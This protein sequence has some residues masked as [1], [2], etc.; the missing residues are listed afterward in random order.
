V[1]GFRFGVFE[2]DVQAG[3]LR[4]SGLKVRLQEQPF[5]VLSML[6]DRPGEVISRDEIR[7]RLWPRDT[8]VDF[9]HSLNAAI[10]RLRESLGD[11]AESPRYIATVPRRGYRFLAPVE[12]VGNGAEQT[13]D[14]QPAGRGPKTRFATPSRLAVA[15]AIAAAA[16][17]VLWVRRPT[18]PAPVQRLTIAPRETIRTPVISPDGK[19]IAFIAGEGDRTKVC[20]QDIN[21]FAP[22]IL[23]GSEGAAEFLFWS[24]DSREVAFVS[25][26]LLRK[27]SV[28][29]GAPFAL[30]RVDGTFLGGA[31]DPQRNTI[32]YCVNRAGIY[33]VPA[34]GGQPKLLVPVDR[35][36]WGDH[37]EYPRFMRS[38]RSE[39][40]LLY[41]A[42]TREHQHAIVV[43]DLVS[44][45]QEQIGIGL[46]ADYSPTGHVLRARQ[47]ALW[48]F[49]FSPQTLRITGEAFRMAPSGAVPYLSVAND[50]TLAY[51][52][53]E[54][55][56]SLAWRDRKGNLLAR[57]GEE[58]P[59]VWMGSFRLSPDGARVATGRQGFS[60]YSEVKYSE[61]WIWDLIRHA[62]T[63]LT[64]GE[65]YVAQPIWHPDGNSVTFISG[66]AGNADIA[67]L[68]ADGSGKVT[69]LAATPL[70]EM[71]DD[72][73]RNGSYLIY[74]VSDPKNKQDLWYLRKKAGGGYERFPLVQTPFSEIGAAF[75]PDSHFI[76]YSSDETGRSEVYVRG[77]PDGPRQQVSVNGGLQPRWR[78]DGKELFYVEGDRLMSLPVSAGKKFSAGIPAALMKSESLRDYANPNSRTYAVSPDGNRILLLE[79]TGP[80]A[81]PVIRIVRNWYSEFRDGQG[82]R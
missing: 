58:D 20:V 49:P 40:I 22:K 32:L 19:L 81:P 11:S 44:G 16:L 12:P 45:K 53:Q 66:A 41:T 6:L 2:L 63:R 77:F 80:Q 8:F 56:R 72:W 71:P 39:R 35:A 9:D 75:S 70:D 55:R 28:A 4:K 14:R 76:A 64:H 73:S 15:S 5:Q 79:Q 37:F 36:R 42:Q 48:A 10:N 65:W 18:H 24:P 26:G 30:S 21:E 68:P 52:E 78:S 23:P 57:E 46:Q 82:G 62:W 67:S 33:E 25:G 1:Q 29:K 59:G 51:I 27:T 60:G 7:E 69:F 13:A 47:L 54:E 3:E 50:G 34:G 38:T 31:W 43:H 74:E 61:I 17:A